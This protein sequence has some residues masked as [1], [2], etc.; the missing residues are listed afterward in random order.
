MTC[1][2]CFNLH[3]AELAVASMLILT[4][5]EIAFRRYV[6]VSTIRAQLRMIFIKTD[7][8]TRTEVTLK[9]IQAG[10]TVLMPEEVR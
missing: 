1:Q 6:T 2:N 10:H 7:S 9:L 3:T 5:K 8:Q 4:N